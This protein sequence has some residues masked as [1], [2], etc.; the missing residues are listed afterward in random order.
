MGVLYART[1]LPFILCAVARSACVV[2]RRCACVLLNTRA[3]LLPVTSPRLPPPKMQSIYNNYTG[4]RREPW[5]RD[6][7]AAA[8]SAVGSRS[9]V[10]TSANAP[11][12]RPAF[13]PAPGLRARSFA[14]PSPSRRH[15]HFATPGWSFSRREGVALV[16]LLASQAQQPARMACEHAARQRDGQGGGSTT[17]GGERAPRGTRFHARHPTPCAARSPPALPTTGSA[18][19]RP[20][21]PPTFARGARSAT[22]VAHACGLTRYS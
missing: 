6:E 9:T 12:A 14:T 4:K 19:H 2:S 8:R 11:S 13:R 3:G 15:N 22:N 18:R 10:R 5:A 1:V 7:H 17:G 21:P 20:C 16:L